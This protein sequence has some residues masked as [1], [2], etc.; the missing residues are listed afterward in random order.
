M[1]T[2]DVDLTRVG[3]PADSRSALKIAIATVF[4]IATLCIALVVWSLTAH[5]VNSGTVVFTVVAGCVGALNFGLGV[6]GIT[7]LPRPTR[8][9]ADRDQIAVTLSNGRSFQ[10]RW[11]DPKL[12]LKLT[13]ML[14]D[15]G[16]A[17]AGA[18]LESRHRPY[19]ALPL[20]AMHQLLEMARQHGLDVLSE[21]QHVKYMGE[22]PLFIIRAKSLT[23]VK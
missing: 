7:R 13:Q 20:P 10:Y 3:L 23:S 14:D 8:L 9:A 12:Q 5:G 21:R 17:E 11:S 19:V 18:A 16:P 6:R 1:T 22:R 15:A 2:L 4:G